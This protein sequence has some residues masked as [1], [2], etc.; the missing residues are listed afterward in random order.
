MEELTKNSELI[1]WVL[2]RDIPFWDW[3][4]DEGFKLAMLCYPDDLMFLD[5]LDETLEL[6]P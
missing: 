1:F 2:Y 4:F 5:P 3:V 6:P